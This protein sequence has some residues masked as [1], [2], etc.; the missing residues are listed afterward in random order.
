M[1]LPQ[2]KEKNADYFGLTQ[3]Q[4]EDRDNKIL[5]S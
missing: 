2:N 1:T 3:T 4:A 5:F